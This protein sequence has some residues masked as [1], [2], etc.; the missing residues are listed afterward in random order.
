MFSRF[1]RLAR[2]GVAM[3]DLG[4]GTTKCSIC[5]DDGLKDLPVGATHERVHFA[6]CV[7]TT[8]GLEGD[9]SETMFVIH[10][11]FSSLV[12]VTPFHVSP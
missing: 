10:P 12:P 2:V 9:F 8:E 1:W 4:R 6:L 3:N 5:H 11:H 7:E